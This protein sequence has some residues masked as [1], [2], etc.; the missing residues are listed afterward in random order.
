MTL[1]YTINDHQNKVLVLAEWYVNPGWVA[2]RNT[3]LQGLITLDHKHNLPEKE[4]LRFI[5]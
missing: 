2:E 4:W 5:I 1:S 3:Q